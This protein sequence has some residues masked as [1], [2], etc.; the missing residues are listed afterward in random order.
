MG[1][2]EMA[3]TTVV[4]ITVTAFIVTAST[5]TVDTMCQALLHTTY[6]LV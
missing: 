5:A 6:S 3:V 4:I 1:T 2:G